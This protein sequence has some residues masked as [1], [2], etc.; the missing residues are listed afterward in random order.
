MSGQ[1]KN[2]AVSASPNSLIGDQLRR[3]FR[4]LRFMPFLEDEYRQLYAAINCRK[5]RPQVALTFLAVVGH[6]VYSIFSDAPA[7]STMLG[8]GIVVL[9]PVLGATM[10]VSLDENRA[11]L[12]QFMLALSAILI[13]LVITSFSVRASLEGRAYFFAAEVAVVM[14]A[15]ML[16]GL[17]FRL[18]ALTALSI[19]V[20]Y[21]FGVLHWD[22]G[23]EESIFALALL[24][25]VNIIGGYCCYLL[26]HASRRTFLESRLL[27][28]LAERDGLTGLYNRR[29]FDQYIQRLWRQSRREHRQL[30]ILMVDIDRFKAY[31]DRYGHQAGDDALRQVAGV[32]AG[33]A[34]RPLDF[35]ARYG[36]EEFVLVLYGPTGQFGRDLPEAIRE[37]VLDLAIPHLDSA[38]DEQLS[39]S[40]GVAIVAPGADRSLAGSIQMADEALYQAK[41]EGRNRVVVKETVHTQIETGRF[42]AAGAE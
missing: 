5:T 8:F 37:S 31:N 9:L 42:R 16:L 38:A 35:A 20:A 15:W 7:S 40:V 19:S 21:V 25:T 30:T 11:R 18:A 32:L 34:Q 24:L 3:G 39:V 2:T 14:V 4:L 36:G 22:F 13:G 41:A 28:E 33:A 10:V 29:S 12:Y 26:E 17:P 23:R 6:I 1:S 27:N